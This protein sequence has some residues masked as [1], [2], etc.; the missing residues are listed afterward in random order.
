MLA[1]I[2]NKLSNKTKIS[3]EFIRFVLIGGTSF[4]IFYTLNNSFVFGLDYLVDSQDETARGL[5][6]WNSYIVAYLIA[7][8]YNFNLSK[9]WTFKSS[10]EN[11]KSKA[12]RFF[13]VNTINALAGAGFVTALD[14]LGVPPWISQP[15]FIGMQTIWTYFFYKLWV[16][17]EKS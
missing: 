6:V 8:V 5:I 1:S 15:F 17:E 13:A 11:V 9:N 16:F 12:I 3:T 2:I 4:V 10:S 14:Y 7:F